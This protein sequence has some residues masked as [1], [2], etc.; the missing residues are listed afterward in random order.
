VE[1][2]NSLSL[3]ADSWDLID[4]SNTRCLAPFEGGVEII[5]RKTD[6]MDPR[7]AFGNE[8]PDGRVLGLSFQQLNE[9]FAS[10]HSGDSCSVGVVQGSFWELEN[11][12]IER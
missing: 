9:R 4:Q 10:G 1:E 3:S 5:H 6:V 11:V 8:L 7:P 12:S 2:G